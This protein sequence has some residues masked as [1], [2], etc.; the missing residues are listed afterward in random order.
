M[1]GESRPNVLLIHSHDTG[2][3]LGCY[4]RDVRTP[5]IDGLAER[6]ARFENYFCTAP[7]CSPSR[8]S[9]VTGRY[10]QRNGLLGLAH[11]GW[12]LNHD[13]VALPAYLADEGYDTH[14]F[15]V[16]HAHEGDAHELG[17]DHVHGG[18]HG[19]DAAEAGAG[20]LAREV[21]PLF[22][23]AMP[24]LAAGAPFFAS[25]GFFEPHA[26]RE[27]PDGEWVAGNDRFDAPPPDEIDVPPNLPDTAAVRQSLST[28]AEDLAAVDY[29]VGR[30]LNAL[31]AAG[32]AD[33]TLV[34]YTT[35]HG[36][37]GPRSKGTLFDGGIETA[38]VIRYP[39]VVEAGETHDELLSNVDLLPT[40][41]DAAGADVPDRV[42]GRSFLGLL[43]DGDYD[44]RDAVYA[45]LTWHV[46]VGPCRA[47][48]T[49]RYKYVENFLTE[50]LAVGASRPGRREGD[51]PWP[52]AELYD[53]EADPYE[54]DNLAEEPTPD[55]GA[56]LEDLRSA[57]HH[58]M[59]D[60]DDPLVDGCVPIPDSD[61]RR[62]GR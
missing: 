18:G 15:G 30:V 46:D 50:Q 60:V 2:C 57:L 40:L 43:T 12:S 9:I 56:P 51:E 52:E 4:G 36:L 25:V 24:G 58:W 7:Q 10:P 54:R 32:V 38:L 31:A 28:T 33:E 23:D 47:I 13:E 39:G 37:G 35:D 45:Q 22:E 62:V 27:T 11:L 44:P 8:G 1:T 17:Y 49:R 5:N 14:V 34:V 6:G 16:Q 42:D 61:R 59:R 19:T 3:H 53:L 29:A 21:A 55:R 48:R 26:I 41:L 20:G